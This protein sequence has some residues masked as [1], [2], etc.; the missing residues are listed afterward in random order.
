VRT[1]LTTLACRCLMASGFA[2]AAT[3]VA[4]AEETAEEVAEETAEET[5]TPTLTL[6]AAYSAEGWVVGDGGLEDGG[7]YLDTAELQAALDLDRAFGWEG[8]QAFA[9]AI[10]GNGNSISEK[11]GDL[12]GPSG[13]E[14]GVEGVRLIEAWIDQT[15]AGGKGSLRAGLYD[16][17]GEFDAGEVRALF[18]N[19]SHGSGPDFS[20]TGQ[21]GPSMWPVTGLGARLNWNFESGAYARVAIVDGVP[22]DLDHPKRTAFDLDDGD[23]ALIVGEAG[24]TNGQGRLWSIGVWGYTEEFPDLVTAETHD[25][26]MGFYVA[27][28]ER[29]G[30]RE[31]GAP[32]DLAGSLR[33]GV[34]NDDI[35]AFEGFFGATLVATGMIDARP[36]D[37]LGLGLAVVNAGDPFR[38]TIADAGG[39]PARHE[40]NIELTYYADVTDWLSVQ[41][42]LQWIINPG[43]DHAIEDAFVAGVRVQVRNTW[44]VID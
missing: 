43:A 37:Q 34:A 2:I 26:N 16:V 1:R 9:Y 41:P 31:N 3:F 39:L 25:D 17:S 22:G 36:N 7:V 15:F 30:S 11:V 24:L 23:G 14:V 10:A 6:Q 12:Q 19:G 20:Q 21:N 38:F 40:V 27:L 29:L 8:A 28:E 4:V 18:V 42:D 44:T 13:Y 35:N 33:F 32:F 5:P